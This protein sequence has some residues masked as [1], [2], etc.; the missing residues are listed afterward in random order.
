MSDQFANSKLAK[1]EEEA[2]RLHAEVYAQ[3]EDAEAPDAEATET[4]DAQTAEDTAEVEAQ[5]ETESEQPAE[6]ETGNDA[7]QETE[8]QDEQQPEPSKED[9]LTVKNAEKR[10]KDAQRRMTKATQEAAA[11][12]RENESLRQTVTDLKGELAKLSAVSKAPEATANDLAR[13]QEEYPDLAKPL[14]AEIQNLRAEQ[15]S[16]RAQQDELRKQQQ[17]DAQQRSALE[18][19][20]AILAVHADAFQLAE[21]VVFQEWLADQP[22]YKRTVV[23]AGTAEDVIDLLNEFKSTL[24]TPKPQPT[25]EQAREIA[26]PKTRSTKA[27]PQGKKNWTRAEINAMSP[28][29]YLKHEADIDR[30]LAEGRVI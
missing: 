4:V 1:L 17:T 19:Q 11:L 25:L 29:E 18:H 30:A 10:I 15:A 22:S 13:L 9:A 20:E 24:A 7:V 6:E 8:Q 5:P 3:K 23:E 2:D 28:A 21:Q 16:A 12:R 26:E 27:K 14:I